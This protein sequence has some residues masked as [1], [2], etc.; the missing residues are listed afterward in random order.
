MRLVSRILFCIFTL[1][2]TFHAS[3]GDPPNNF[4]DK[5]LSR[6]D[7]PRKLQGRVNYITLTYHHTFTYICFNNDN[8]HDIKFIYNHYD[9]KTYAPYDVMVVHGN[10]PIDIHFTLPMTY[11][12]YFFY[13]ERGLYGLD[14][15]LDYL[16]SV[17]FSFFDASELYTMNMCFE[18]C[19]NLETVN[20]GNFFAPKLEYTEEMFF[21]CRSIQYL[22][23][24]K[25][26][27]PN[28]VNAN[29]MFL[30]CFD[31]K[32]LDLSN[33]FLPSLKY[34][35]KIFYMTYRLGY[36]ILNSFFS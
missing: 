11:M 36:V 34:A 30:N 19:M 3:I 14:H 5:S 25:F 13:N 18:Y 29:K 6:E 31:L 32:L 24:S 2:N 7:S 12:N 20:F 1:M 23:L 33:L 16:K 4:I 10:V 8:R 27:A 28:L 22:N 17:D 15:N 35:E 9:G 26:Y 21:E